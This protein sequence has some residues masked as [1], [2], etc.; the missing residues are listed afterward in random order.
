MCVCVCL[1]GHAIDQAPKLFDHSLYQ[2]LFVSVVLPELGEDVVLLTGILHP[3]HRETH[4][5]IYHT[6][7]FSQ[8]IIY[9]NV[10]N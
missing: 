4:G 9:K 10:T 3:E 5:Q 1:G 8:C 2:L 7:V 6:N